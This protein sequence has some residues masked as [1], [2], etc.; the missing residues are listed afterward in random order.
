MD[1]DTP[2]LHRLLAPTLTSVK[3][4]DQIK[5]KSKQLGGIAAVDIDVDLIQMAL[6]QAQEFELGKA[7]FVTIWTA[8]KA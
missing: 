5:L 4:L 8:S 1:G 7:G 3:G 6:A 2:D